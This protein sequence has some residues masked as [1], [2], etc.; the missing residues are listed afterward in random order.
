MVN[1]WLLNH[2]SIRGCARGRAHSGQM[3]S[4]F[5]RAGVFYLRSCH[6]QIECYGDFRMNPYA[7]SAAVPRSILRRFAGATGLNGDLSK[8]GM[9]RKS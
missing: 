6:N 2:E 1:A 7:I 3:L 8:S 5:F 4:M 9:V